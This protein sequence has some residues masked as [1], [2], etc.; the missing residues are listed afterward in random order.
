[1]KPTVAAPLRPALHAEHR[2]ITSVLD[3]TFPQGDALPSERDLADLLGVTRP[4]V[5]E[6]LQ[7]LSAERWVTIRHGKPT[8]VNTYWRDGGLGM[9]GTMARYVDYLPSDFI[10]CLLEVRLNLLPDCGQAAAERGPDILLSHLAGRERLQGDAGDYADFDWQLQ[11]LM[12]R[13][14]GNPIYGLI[15][16]DFR[17]IYS[18]LAAGY[19][20][21]PDAR[22]SSDNYYRALELAIHNDTGS[23]YETVR[24]VMQES[25][26][27]W[28][29]VQQKTGNES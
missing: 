20:L 14:C 11:E 5:R 4:T 16:N 29:T 6:T 21:L 9:L 10:T 7:R 12:V 18:R 24:A 27:I 3:G 2:I 1:M 19:F 28:I 22:H 13:T 17:D 15:L 8:V 26:R 25:I 23:V